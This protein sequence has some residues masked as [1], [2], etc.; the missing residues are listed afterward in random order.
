MTQMRNNIEIAAGKLISSIQKEWN[1]ELGDPAA[2]ED[3][4][5]MSRAHDLLQASKSGQIIKLLKDSS[6]TDYLGAEWV[7][8]HKAV[9]PAIELFQAT[10][11]ST[12][13]V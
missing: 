11:K 9:Q 4:I 2:E 6:I 5:V 13:S 1:R 10:M 3:E 12:T 7:K 8:K